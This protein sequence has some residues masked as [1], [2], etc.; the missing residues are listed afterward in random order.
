MC[1]ARFAGVEVDRRM[2]IGAEGGPDCTPVGWRKGQCRSALLMAERFPHGFAQ[3]GPTVTQRFVALRL[4]SGIPGRPVAPS[5]RLSNYGRSLGR[6]QAAKK[7]AASDQASLGWLVPVSAV[8]SGV[9][10]V[11]QASASVVCT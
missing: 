2:H 8:T 6:R 5:S 3:P 9:L 1:P 10:A 11:K 7:L 4:S